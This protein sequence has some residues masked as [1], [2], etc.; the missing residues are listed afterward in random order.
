MIL[1]TILSV[2]I[3]AVTLQSISCK[4]GGSDPVPETEVQRVTKLLVGDATSGTQWNILSVKVDDIDYTEV[5]T[6]FT[7]TF[8]ENGFTSTNGTIVFNDTDTWSFKD[9]TAKVITTS[10]V[11]ITI[12]EITEASLIFSFIWEGTVYGEGGRKSAVGGENVFTMTR[13]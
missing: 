4:S 5:F 6:G 3:L 2:F 13:N 8:S 10:N 9:D 7:L 11:D 12:D 1:R